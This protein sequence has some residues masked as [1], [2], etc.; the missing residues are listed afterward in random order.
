MKMTFI[1][2]SKL[3]H[4]MWKEKTILNQYLFQNGVLKSIKNLK[5]NL[6]QMRGK[7]GNIDGRY[8]RPRPQSVQF[9]QHQ[10][11]DIGMNGTKVPKNY[12]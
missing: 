9:N 8:N 12:F 5:I 6:I 7:G 4:T 1:I 3:E 11:G 10:N 2:Y